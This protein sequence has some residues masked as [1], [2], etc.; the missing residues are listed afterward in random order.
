MRILI[1]GDFCPRDRVSQLIKTDKVEAVFASV[2]PIV[3]SV[4][5]AIVNF[6]CAV[7]DGTT[8][9]IKKCGPNLKCSP[10]AVSVIK[11]AGFSCVTLANNHF[12]DFGNDGVESSLAAFGSND[13]D[14]VGG[15]M[16]ISK[17][18][19]VLFKKISGDTL[20]IINACEYEFS[21]A[22]TKRAGSAPLDIVNICHQIE[23]AR[24]YAK[25]VLVIIHGGSEHYQL[26]SVRMKKTYRFFIEM[27]ADAVINHHQHCY[28]GYEMYM[29]KPI[30]YGLGN[31]CFDH[32]KKRHGIWN[33]GYM[34]VLDWQKERLDFETI[35]YVQCDD[36]PSVRIMDGNE[37]VLFKTKIQELNRIIA[38]DI[39]LEN[40]YAAFMSEKKKAVLG[41]F[42]PYVNE[43]LRAAASRHWLPYLLPKKTVAAMLDYIMC[44]SQRDATIAVF[45]KML[46][47]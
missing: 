13:L 5:Y 26:P 14:Y 3:D 11:Q 10:E 30:F 24:K 7:A 45:K 12:R 2:K 36:T 19:R 33:Q 42:T 4:D 22:D 8:M 9:P 28:S 32:P 31:F 37:K 21:I 16:N 17:A 35:P 47:D 25:F 44:E 6:E 29:R 34:V 20:A 27:G 15:G 43:Y 38:N 1:A 39:L 46:E 40:A 23:E 18:E 41:V